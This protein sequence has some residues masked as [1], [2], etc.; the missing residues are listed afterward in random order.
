M[1]VARVMN[2]EIVVFFVVIL[3]D[4]SLPFF[5]NRI[6]FHAIEGVFLVR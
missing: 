4:P 1:T 6:L 2:M 3:E 5:H